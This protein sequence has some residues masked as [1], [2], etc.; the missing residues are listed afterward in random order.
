MIETIEIL[1]TNKI[2][3][4]LLF[5]INH[6]KPET[7]ELM[8]YF[9]QMLK[10]SFVEKSLSEQTQKLAMFAGCIDSVNGEEM[11]YCIENEF[12]KIEGEW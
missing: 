6:S 12:N 4:H 10:K 5:E 11:S 8:Y 3:E 7:L 9:I 2:R 1:G